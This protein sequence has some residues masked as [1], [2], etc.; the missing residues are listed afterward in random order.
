[1]QEKLIIRGARE[2]NLRNVDFRI[3]LATFV[4]VTGVSGSG[5]STLVT[6]VLYR[7]LA[8]ELNGSR[9]PVGKHVRDALNA[10]AFLA[11][12]GKPVADDGDLH[13]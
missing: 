10:A 1:M 12:D 9:E 3:P 7:A 6:E 11:S 13:H 8:R 2:H 4:A 5:K